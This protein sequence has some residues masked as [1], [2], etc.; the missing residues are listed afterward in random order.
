MDYIPRKVNAGP[1]QPRAVI[2][3]EIFWGIIAREDDKKSVYMLGVY[4][5]LVYLCFGVGIAPMF[6]WLDTRGVTDE[7]SLAN[8]KDNLSNAVVP[9][10]MIFC[11]LGPVLAAVFA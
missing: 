8:R 9:F 2:K 3:D 10:N 7:A 1:H 5:A 6:F 11:F 4:I